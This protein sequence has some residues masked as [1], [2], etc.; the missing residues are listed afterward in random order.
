MA[1][2]YSEKRMELINTLRGQI[3]E[4]SVCKQMVYTVTTEL[5]NIFKILNSVGDWGIMNK[6]RGLGVT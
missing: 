6:N 1:D 2:Y 5:L 3:V 4:L